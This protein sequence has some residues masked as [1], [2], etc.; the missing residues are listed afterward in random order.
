G[1]QANVTLP[2]QRPLTLV[3]GAEYHLDLTFG[4][5]RA[6]PWAQAGYELCEVQ[7]ALPW[8]APVVPPRRRETLAIL[9]EVKH[10]SEPRFVADGSELAFDPVF[11]RVTLWRMAGQDL[12][13]E[14]PRLQLW[15][16]PI[17]NERMGSGK[18]IREGWLKAKLDQLQHRIDNVEIEPLDEH[19]TQFRV[20]AR[21]APPTSAIAL[22]CRYVYTLFGSGELTIAVEGTFTGDWPEMLPRIGLEL[23]MPG[24]FD[25]VTWFGLG[26][27]ENYTDTRR[28][29]RVDVHHAT[30][31]QLYTPYVYPQ[32]NGNRSDVRW[33]ALRNT[34]GA[35]LLVLGQPYINFSAHRYT[36]GDLQHATHTSEL[37]PR[38]FITLHLDHAQN[39]IGSGSCGTRLSEAY[40]L[41]PKP[42]AFSVHLRPVVAVAPS[43]PALARQG[44]P[45]LRG[46]LTPSV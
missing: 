44:S 21:I 8:E 43:L 30:V 7:F 46:T 11:G 38:P 25:Q 34:S 23:A 19:A 35:G 2:I 40:Q 14:G 39:G 17:D 1:A 22:R 24:K 13:T 15:R 26:P 3:S 5:A 27:G 20:E 32:E 33:L 10:V 42:F 12:L 31:D 9:R 41:K 4:L 16:A 28:A 37:W 36:V 6:T 29:T 45:E 18:A